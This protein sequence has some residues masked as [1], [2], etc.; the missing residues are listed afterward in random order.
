MKRRIVKNLGI[1]LQLI[2][3]VLGTGYVSQA[4]AETIG[5]AVMALPS[6]PAP[7]YGYLNTPYHL[8]VAVPIANSSDPWQGV[9]R[10]RVTDRFGNLLYD[11]IDPN[12]R[13]FLDPVTKNY[14]AACKDSADPWP[15]KRMSRTHYVFQATRLG[16]YTIEFSALSP[17]KKNTFRATHTISI[18]D[19]L[20][21]CTFAG[22][23]KD[24]LNNPVAGVAVEV[25][26]GSNV[27][28]TFTTNTYGAYG[29]DKP[30]KLEAGDYSLRATKRTND[31]N[32][33]V[34]Y[35]LKADPMKDKLDFKVRLVN[36]FLHCDF[37]QVIK[38][39]ISGKVT[40]QDGKGLPKIELVLKD[41]SGSNIIASSEPTGVDGVY[42]MSFV[43]SSPNGCKIIP[44]NENFQFVPPTILISG[45]PPWKEKDFKAIPTY[46]F[47]AKVTKQGSTELL[48]KVAI[49]V[50]KVGSEVP[51]LQGE[52]DENGEYNPTKK[53]V[54]GSYTVTAKKSGY[55]IDPQSPTIEVS[56]DTI[57]PFVAKPGKVK[58]KLIV[59]IANNDF[60]GLS[61]ADVTFTEASP[62][63]TVFRPRSLTGGSYL[64]GEIEAQVGTG[65]IGVSINNPNI[66]IVPPNP[67]NFKVEPGFKRLDEI[68]KT[69]KY[70]DKNASL[71][72]APVNLAAAS[73]ANVEG[74]ITQVSFQPDDTAG[75]GTSAKCRVEKSPS[76]SGPWAR[77]AKS[78]SVNPDAD[79][80]T[81]SFVDLDST[82]AAGTTYYRVIASNADG[83]SAPAIISVTAP[84]S[85]PAAGDCLIQK[86][87]WQSTSAGY[88]PQNSKVK[89]IAETNGGNSEE[90]KFYILLDGA[91]KKVLPATI[92]NNKAEA[93]W[94]TEISENKDLDTGSRRDFNEYQFMI[95]YKDQEYQLSDKL[96]V[97]VGPDAINACFDDPQ[98]NC[99][100]C[101]YQVSINPEKLQNLTNPNIPATISGWR[102]A[103][104]HGDTGLLADSVCLACLDDKQQPQ[105]LKYKLSAL[106]ELAAE[107]PAYILM[108]A[109]AM[110]VL[111]RPEDAQDYLPEEKTTALFNLHRPI[112]D[113]FALGI[114]QEDDDA[115]IGFTVSNDYLEKL[116]GCNGLCN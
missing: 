25:L 41:T 29:S 103:P 18:C 68:T 42:L 60:S 67:C 19:K 15:D 45:T 111:S 115:E 82:A 53:L 1:V 24:S 104:D 107:E 86:A 90:L 39:E 7:A 11:S 49:K 61:G 91:V 113:S 47:R 31:P 69:F 72:R 16:T 62:G 99:Y 13:N 65:V 57:V 37:K 98:G 44:T 105:S 88:A 17:S 12:N 81:I 74:S 34:K 70:D 32:N 112:A 3:I 59:R 52:T 116:K 75:A 63:T 114:P 48:P 84:N 33:E 9:M 96:V 14:I 30:V 54:A 76:E 93:E 58:F 101:A 51:A 5:I 85:L 100:R 77:V 20:Y 50:I 87:Y 27:K 38:Y 102:L 8:S 6:G 40:A 36:D 97:G 64:F 108:T 66:S 21:D 95:T 83:D 10:T 80:D 94:S 46:A 78:F 92:V 4:I 106:D 2:C 79:S 26:S 71:P 35:S 55:E 56:K 23:V 89:L 22:E 28:Y 43:T 110:K 109:E 73:I